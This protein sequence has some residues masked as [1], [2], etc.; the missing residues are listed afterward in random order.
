MTN[1]RFDG[2]RSGTRPPQFLFEP[3][4]SFN[5]FLPFFSFGVFLSISQS[6][7][8]PAQ[9]SLSLLIFELVLRL[10]K[11][12]I[13]VLRLSSFNPFFADPPT[14]LFP[15]FPRP[16]YTISLD[17]ILSSSQEKPTLKFLPYAEPF[18][19]PLR[20]RSPL[21][22]PRLPPPQIQMHVSS[23]LSPLCTFPSSFP[24]PFP[25][26]PGRRP[27]KAVGGPS[28]HPSSGRS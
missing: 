16:Q 12:K 17:T 7:W 24:P 27:A 3:P 9:S 8:V 6:S 1:A 4:I 22:P 25:V 20:W 15:F 19:T 2:F 14:Y 28:R 5:S 11:P 18:L 13:R 23:H 26:L 10:I 21:S